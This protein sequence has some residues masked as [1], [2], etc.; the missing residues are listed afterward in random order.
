MGAKSLV[1]VY[2]AAEGLDQL[3]AGY[4]AREQSIMSAAAGDFGLKYVAIETPPGTDA[5]AFARSMTGS[6]LQRQRARRRALLLRPGH[7]SE[8][9]GRRHRRRRHTSSTRRP[10]LRAPAYAAVLGLDLTS[11][12]GEAR[13]ERSIVEQAVSRLG[14]KGRL[15]LW[16]ADYA[17]ASVAGMAE[18]AQR[19]SA[20]NGAS[21][22]RPQAPSSSR[23]LDSRSPGGSLDS[24]IRRRPVYWRQVGEPRAPARRT[25]TFSA[26]ATCRAPCSRYPASTCVAGTAI[27]LGPSIAIRPRLDYY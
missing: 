19:A 20:A 15:G 23:H 9:L 17:R 24:G 12:K 1:A 3:A 22:G 6:W 21:E 10:R 11:A 14:L 16:D 2:S 25:S 4:A 8:P 18:F 26:R 13:K 27:A 7:C 5:A